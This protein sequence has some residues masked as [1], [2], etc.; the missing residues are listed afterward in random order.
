MSVCT[1]L[2]ERAGQQRVLF[3]LLQIH[4][5]TVVTEMA[6]RCGYDFLFLD[7]EHGLFD[8]ADVLQALQ[9]SAATE[10]LAL[11]RLRQ[12]DLQAIGRYLDM[13]VHGIVVPNVSNA[14]QARALARAFEYPPRGTRGFAAALHRST[15]YGQK[16]E[17]H[18]VAPR[19]GA[20]LIVIVE[21]AAGVDNI[22]G[23]L[24]TDGVDG[25]LIGIWDLTADLGCPGDFSNEQFAAAVS[26]IEKAAQASGK[27]LG[28][29]PYPG[30]SL[31]TLIARGHQVIVLDA[32]VSLLV[33]TMSANV[34]RARGCL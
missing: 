24:G 11:I 9:V 29:A 32:D 28:T 6:G 26:R 19:Q 1:T 15:S 4:P 5:N 14:D 8:E 27:M 7:G 23:I 22:D 10:A 2:L 34:A 16:L 31:E 17:Q 12:H 21:S 33:E 25:V 30:S 18:L 13:G 20:C 3:G